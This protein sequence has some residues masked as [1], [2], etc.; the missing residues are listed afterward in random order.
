MVVFTLFLLQVH[1]VERCAV[2]LMILSGFSVV[3]T[4]SAS[5]SKMCSCINDAFS[6]FLVF[7]FKMCSYINDCGLCLVFTSSASC[8]KICSC[9]ND[10]FSHLIFCFYFQCIMFKNV[11]LY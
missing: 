1:H 3:F 11:Q 8:S 2:V 7:T 4:S 6:N 10:A 9:I 5:R